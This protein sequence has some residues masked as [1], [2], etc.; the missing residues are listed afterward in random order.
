MDEHKIKVIFTINYHTHFGENLY[1]VGNISTFG[2][3]VPKNGFP[4]H[5]QP[6]NPNL[7]GN[8]SLLEW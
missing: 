2:K 8:L 5:Y 6:V 3:W 4:L 1:I 7:N